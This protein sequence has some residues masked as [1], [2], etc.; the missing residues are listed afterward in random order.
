MSV[1]NPTVGCT[2]VATSVQLSSAVQVLQD[3]TVNAFALTSQ[4]QQAANVLPT[5]L[6][7]VYTGATS[8][9]LPPEASGYTQKLILTAPSVVTMDVNATV[10]ES[11]YGNNNVSSLY[12]AASIATVDG[13]FD[14][15]V[16]SNA[17]VGAPYVSFGP[18]APGLVK[19]SY[20]TA[21]G[22]LPAS[23]GVAASLPAGTYYLY[24]EGEVYTFTDGNTPPTPHGTL[25]VVFTTNITVTPVGI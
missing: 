13:A 25:D 22:P 9:T 2:A 15:D 11:S 8:T 5:S 7:Q 3:G 20:S 17:Y 19:F 1:I 23:T 4:N 12:V 24:T 14:T 6:V 18:L 10:G 21:I 16:Y